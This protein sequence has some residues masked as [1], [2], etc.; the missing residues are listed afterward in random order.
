M[1]AK[2]PMS[3]SLSASSKTNTSSSLSLKED[4]LMKYSILPGVPI[5]MLPPS[6]F[7]LFVSSLSSEAPPVSKNGLMCRSLNF[8]VKVTATSCICTANS[9]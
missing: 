6:L 9:L 7:H 3:K 2:K 5:T 1:E 8:D 4:V